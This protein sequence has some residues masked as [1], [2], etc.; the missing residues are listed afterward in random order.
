GCDIVI[1]LFNKGELNN[2]LASV[3][4]KL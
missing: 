4:A 2:L 1:D 3:T